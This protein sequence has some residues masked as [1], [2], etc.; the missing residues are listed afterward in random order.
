MKL[1]WIFFCLIF[2]HNKILTT[3]NDSGYTKYYSECTQCQR[4]WL[5]SQLT[6]KSHAVFQKT[7]IKMSAPAKT[8]VVKVP[9][10]KKVPKKSAYNFYL[11]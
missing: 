6:K 11:L 8:I 2:G 4:K 3:Q 9:Q 10:V 5:N 7:T 1:K